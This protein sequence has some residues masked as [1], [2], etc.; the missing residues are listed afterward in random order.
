[1]DRK[2]RRTAFAHWAIPFLTVAEWAGFCAENCVKPEKNYPEESL[3][4]RYAEHTVES[5]SL[6]L[7]SS[8]HEHPRDGD[9]Q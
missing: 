4:L 2:I 3:C 8:P 1:M 7:S 9:E 6:R 5:N